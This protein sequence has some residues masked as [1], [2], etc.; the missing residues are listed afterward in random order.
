MTLVLAVLAARPAAPHA[1]DPWSVT[2]EEALG[3]LTLL[4]VTL[5][6]LLGLAWTVLRPAVAEWLQEVPSRRE[7][8]GWAT[9]G[10]LLAGGLAWV[11]LRGTFFDL[12]LP[13]PPPLE[14]HKHYTEH[15]GVVTMWGD[16]HVE[17]ARYRSTGRP[18]AQG[19][20]EE[21]RVWLTDAYRRPISNEHFQG[22]ITVTPPP[23][24]ARPAA[25]ARR[26]LVPGPGGP[27]LMARYPL[28]PEKVVVRLQLRAPGQ[29]MRFRVVFDGKAPVHPPD[30][31][32]E[33]P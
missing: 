3:D 21:Y 33:V 11:A 19:A 30:R 13:P 1:G 17:V 6:V 28:Q 16:Y 15:G 2:V 23:D 18:M 9:V 20:G 32:C 5:G 24:E 31:W 29:A 12:F 26:D 4:L 7:W 25:G 10:G 14:T 22:S 27:Y 8:L